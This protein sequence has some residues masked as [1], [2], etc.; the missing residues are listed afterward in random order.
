MK[1]F[2]MILALACLAACSSTP[3]VTKS[4][5]SLICDPGSALD[6]KKVLAQVDGE[7]ITEGD[8]NERI[9]PGLVRIQ[10]EIYDAKKQG[11]DQMIIER[12]IEKEAKKQ[13]VTEE[14]LMKV[15]VQEKAGDMTDQEVQD[16]FNQNKDRFG[17]RSF[18]DIKIPLKQQLAKRKMAIYQD[19]F[20]DR[21]KGKA[22]IKILLEQ[23]RMDVSADDDPMKG[24]KDAKVTIIEFT[25]YQCPYCGKARP[26]VNKINELYGDKIKYVL[27]DYPLPPE[28]H[29]NAMKAAEA[30]N[31][32]RDQNKYWE[33]SDVLW[34]NQGHLDVVDLKKYAQDL[35][36]NSKDFDACLDSDKYAQEIKK[37]QAD[38]ATVGV[39]GTPTFFINGKML[40]GA[41]NI[42][43]FQKTID[44]ELK[45]N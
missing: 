12:L 25:D 5:P 17:G 29:P 8:L 37:D 27:R 21:L 18:D 19:N 3:A 26:T 45:K 7:A 40:T 36:L 11:L 2:G 38:G 9:A 22:D 32:A 33:Y 42:E 28:M 41:I 35:K 1:K 15:E 20:L 34:A 6:P 10:S 13:G 43:E 4:A 44:S 23:P 39:N 14:K 31:C 30:A 16:F 24:G